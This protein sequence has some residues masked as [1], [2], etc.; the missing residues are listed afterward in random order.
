MTL[1]DTD[2]VTVDV[3]VEVCDGVS[4]RERELLFDSDPDMERGS[5]GECDGDA[6]SVPLDLVTL[7]E[8]VTLSDGERD[9]VSVGVFEF[10]GSAE[11]EKDGDPVRVAVFVSEGATLIVSVLLRIWVPVPVWLGSSVGLSVMERCCVAVSVGEAVISGVAL[12]DL[13]AVISTV[14]DTDEEC[15][16]S[17][18]GDSEDERV[19]VSDSVVV[20]SR[21]IDSLGV[22]LGENE[23]DADTSCEGEAENDGESEKVL[24]SDS[25][26]LCDEVGSAEE[27]KVS[28]GDEEPVSEAL[29]VAECE[30]VPLTE[31]VTDSELV[32]VRLEEVV[33][34]DENVVDCEKDCV[35]DVLN[36]R[37]AENVKD[38]LA[39]EESDV[40]AVPELEMVLETDPVIDGLDET[41]CE[42]L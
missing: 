4:L 7:G 40:V 34:L 15:V 21:V 11:S 14:G 41:V 9:S 12:S 13:L 38:S 32:P 31:N 25:V 35:A 28:D 5:E 18:V 16:R 24:L 19:R 3:P 8:G 27:E 2:S 37:D 29:H 36:V 6:V 17:R 33:R 10:V 22:P 1:S 42:E 20:L 39:V 30:K 26:W 23:S